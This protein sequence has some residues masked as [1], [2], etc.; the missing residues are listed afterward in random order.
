MSPRFS[1]PY[2]A[3]TT[4][5]FSRDIARSIPQAGG[6]R[7]VSWRPARRA[8]MKIS[9]GVKAYMGHADISTTVVWA[10]HVPHL[11]AA[12]RLSRAIDADSPEMCPEM[13]PELSR[14]Q[15]ISANLEPL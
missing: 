12:E 6:R 10:H 3:R 11:D 9:S 8:S 13:C 15:T 1:A 7:G 4:S 5:T 14:F 2:I